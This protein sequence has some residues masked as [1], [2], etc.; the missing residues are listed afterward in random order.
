MNSNKTYKLL[1]I[2]SMTIFGTI[3]L[4]VRNINLPSGEIALY[5]AVLASLL[6]GTFLLIKKQKIDFKKI[7]NHV[8]QYVY[9]DLTKN[10]YY[11]QQSF[12]IFAHK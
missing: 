5:R 12:E 1:L 2:S 10:Q 9:D 4:F 11:S 8:P 6:I 7:K 3:A